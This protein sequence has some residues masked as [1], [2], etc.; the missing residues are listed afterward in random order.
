MSSL[1]CIFFFLSVPDPVGSEGLSLLV[2]DY[3]WDGQETGGQYEGIKVLSV[4]SGVGSVANSHLHIYNALPYRPDVDEADVPRTTHPGAGAFT[5]YHNHSFYSQRP[6]AAGGEVFLNY[7][8]NWFRE[9][10]AKKKI[11][12]IADDVTDTFDKHIRSIDWLRENGMCLDNIRAGRST[13]KQ[14][15][16]GAFATRFLPKDAVIAPAPLVQITDR[17]ALRTVRV[18]A[19]ARK[20]KPDIVEKGWQLLLNYVYGHPKSSML[21]LPYGTVINLIN[22]DSEKPNAVLRW[23]NWTQHRGRDWPQSMSID[24]LKATDK[25]GLM[26]EFVAT[27][28]IDPGEEIFIDYGSNWQQ[29]WDDHVESWK[30][31]PG[32]SSYTPS[33]IMDDVAKVVR[34]EEEQRNYPYGDN[35]I[36]SCFYRY[37]DIAGADGSSSTSNGERVETTA[38]KWEMKRGIFDLTNLRPCS[39]LK[40][41]Q[42]PDGKNHFYTVLVRNRYGLRKEER[43]PKGVIQVVNFVPRAAIRFSDKIYTTDHHLPNVFRHEIGLPGGIFPRA[44]MDLEDE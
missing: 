7:G 29:A 40:R 28:D 33:Y 38:V 12:P 42:T 14:A 11:P 37:S 4:V 25:S 24:E 41:D 43:I 30:P 6:I 26:L 21:F 15:G 18:K 1:H 44:W 2:S 10:E 39:I 31:V 22:H 34:T 19:A 5:H 23:S 20:D 13:N 8:L 35:I 3:L 9:R 32:A 27:R 16:R 36:T 17:N